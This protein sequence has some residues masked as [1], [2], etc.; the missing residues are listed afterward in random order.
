MVRV[1]LVFLFSIKC[2][3]SAI[4]SSPLTEISKG[5]Y[6]FKILFLNQTSRIPFV[7]FDIQNG[8][9]IRRSHS[10][11]IRGYEL[12]F[13]LKKR[14]TK[15]QLI[16][17]NIYWINNGRKQQIN[18]LADSLNV[19]SVNPMP[20]KANDYFKAGGQSSTKILTE[21]DNDYFLFNK[22]IIIKYSILSKSNFIDYKISKFP[23]FTGFIKRFREMS[24][25]SKQIFLDGEYWYQTPL[26]L[27][28]IFPMYGEEL[29]VHPM[30]VELKKL[31]RSYTVES[32]K[33]DP[34]VLK[35]FSEDVLFG[36]NN[37]NLYPGEGNTYD[38]NHPVSILV[39]ISGKGLIENYEPIL[40]EDLK[41]FLIDKAI[42]KQNYGIPNAKKIINYRFR[43][44]KEGSYNGSFSIKTF[45]EVSKKE[46]VKTKEFSFDILPPKLTRDFSYS[47]RLIKDFSLLK[48]TF[49]NKIQLFFIFVL[50]FYN[51]LRK[52]ISIFINSLA[53]FRRLSAKG[54]DCYTELFKDFYKINDSQS[55]NFKNEGMIF[56][57][58]FK[59]KSEKVFID[60]IE[61]RNIKY[62]S[63][64]G[65]IKSNDNLGFFFIYMFIRNLHKD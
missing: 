45:D 26:Y 47:K 62:S 46:V 60:M 63:G 23:K 44:P 42:E 12:S 1:L 34:N 40:N 21:I 51:F 7:N 8:I 59:I 31:G 28:E 57:E 20:S 53:T 49:V 5:N 9:L 52:E 27:V 55:F 17:E 58:E 14:N 54:I 15:K 13:L 32:E 36:E 3:S 33:F 25:R 61:K 38:A 56:C 65:D 4:V 29:Q 43:F 41:K 22:G 50:L 24:S 2:F 10:R 30:A 35:A 18:S 48:M 39:E 6:Q 16:I 37:I 11:T 19:P 64:P